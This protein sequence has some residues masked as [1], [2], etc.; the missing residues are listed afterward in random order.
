MTKWLEGRMTKEFGDLLSADDHRAR[1]ARLAYEGRS[2]GAI[3][4]AALVGKDMVALVRARLAVNRDASS[5][6]LMKAV[7]AAL[8]K[9]PLYLL[10][11]IQILRRAGKLEDAAK[12][13]KAAPRD[14]A[15]LVDL[16]EWWT[17]RRV[18]AR[19]LLDDKKNELAYEV[20]AGHVKADGET[21]IE[22]EFH[23]GWI[24][25]RFLDD[26]IRATRHFGKAAS[27]A[28]TPISRART[29]YWQG[30][31]AEARG[32]KAVA[33]SF[34]EIAAEH[35][36]AYYGQL[37]SAHLGDTPPE[38]RRPETIATGVA[39]TPAIRVVEM[40]LALD[41][42]DLARTLAFQT[43][44]TLDDESQLAALADVLARDGDARATLVVGKLATQRGHVLDESAF[45]TFGIPA[46]EAPEGAAALPVVYAI[47]RQESAFAAK[48]VSHA[49]AKGL[50]QMIE[51]DG[52]PNRETTRRGVRQSAPDG[53]P[54]LQCAARSGPSRASSLAISRVL[55]TDVRGL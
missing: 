8:Q 12:A 13:M 40:L 6:K 21:E 7:P 45:P 30:R 34:Y 35:P 4:A 51:L 10:S 41:E 26:P 54:G 24:A 55:H 33:R 27:I 52:A 39:R 25:L 16:D 1:A 29:A 18:L 20:A 28:Q 50:M 31:A 53:G 11:R 2:A 22:A 5:D 3:R 43:G 32:D 36:I 47:A 15:I 38:M 17:E 44:R 23:A 48:V 42:K 46:F 9:D 37:A 49:G 14:P 19:E